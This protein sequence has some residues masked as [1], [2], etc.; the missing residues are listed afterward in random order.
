MRKIYTIKKKSIGGFAYLSLLLFIAL[1]GFVC[2]SAV[3]VG[4]LV[5]RRSVEEALLT[6][7]LE[8]SKALNSYAQN[9]PPGVDDEPLSLQ[10]LLLDTRQPGRV[11]RHLRK[12]YPDPITGSDQWGVII[13]PDTKRI[14]GVHS[15]STQK[16]IKIGGFSEAFSG[17]MNKEKISDWIFTA[18]IAQ[19]I[20]LGKDSLMSDK[21]AAAKANGERKFI[22]PSTLFDPTK[23]SPVEQKPQIREGF[24]SPTQLQD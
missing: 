22:N 19:S 1:L 16:P 18:E 20:E 24:I 8:Y 9:S 3:Q 5:H 7:G 17:F 21:N 10:E 11:M 15:L 12:I 23:S 6:I 13:D 2:A 14:G 4:G